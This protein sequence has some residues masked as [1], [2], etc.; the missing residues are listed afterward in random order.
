MRK[1][2]KYKGT[3]DYLKDALS[4][5]QKGNLAAAEAAYLKVISTAP[6]TALAW[7]N[8]AIIRR[9]QGYPKAAVGLNLRAMEVGK[10]PESVANNLFNALRDAN[11]GNEALSLRTID[12]FNKFSG[13][14]I[15]T[16]WRAKAL[17][18][19]E[20]AREALPFFEEHVRQ[21]KQ[22]TAA[23]ADHS[24]ALF[25]AGLM[26]KGLEIY[27]AR[28]DAKSVSLPTTGHRWQGESIEGKEIYVSE[29]QGF[30]DT[31]FL[32]RF[33]P[34]LARLKPSKIIMIARRPMLRLLAH[35]DMIDEVVDRKGFEL[36]TDAT[37]L[38]GFDL[39]K[40]FLPK[41]EIFP[42]PAH[43]NVPGNAITRAR[44]IITPN[45]TRFKIG[46]VWKT[47]KVGRLADAK[48]TRLDMFLPILEI[49]GVQLFSLHKEAGDSDIKALGLEGLIIDVGNSDRDFAD[50]AA[51][52]QELDL[53]ITID[54]AVAHLAG[55]LGKPVW[56]LTPEPPFWY[57][58]D[59]G[60]HSRFYPSM[61]V[62]RQSTSGD[63]SDVFKRVVNDLT[64]MLR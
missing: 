32:T 16:S 51:I 35:M 60:E 40:H 49:P 42:S 58:N 26:H 31:F 44:Q 19:Q 33:L 29:E 46:I 56:M 17:L 45:K 59:I 25:K 52:I 41:D 55:A 27:E 6:K 64:R 3:G 43:F 30:G 54:T 18:L 7:G 23:G 39:A 20:R 24:L 15:S 62:I 21:E 4:A 28:W 9:S 63:W 57:W 37:W 47:E 36:P 2:T 22:P 5:H 1:T 10:T 11:R 8:L 38:V 13:G 14:P 12:P 34:N 53:V 48:S 61:R 50:T